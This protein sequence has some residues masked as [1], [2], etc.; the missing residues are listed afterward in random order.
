MD[1]AELS[2]NLPYF[3]GSDDVHR[4]S[5]L[6][7]R[8]FLSDGAKFLA[9]NAGGGA[10]WLMDLIASYQPRLIKRGERFQVWTIKRKPGT[11]E[12]SVYC[13]DGNAHDK[14][15]VRQ[16]I[17]Y[18]DFPLDKFQLYA[19]WDGSALVIKLPNEY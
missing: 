15:L 4:W 8:F 14:Y 13:T 3:I 11:S 12:A 6:F 17:L 16:K 19:I 2:E 9:D 18:T 7:P 10:Y 5:I 1:A